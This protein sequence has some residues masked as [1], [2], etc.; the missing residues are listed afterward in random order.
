MAL[1]KTEGEVVEGLGDAF[2]VVPNA[3]WRE[4]KLFEEA[5]NKAAQ[6][7]LDAGALWPITFDDGEVLAQEYPRDR[8]LL[9][10]FAKNVRGKEMIYPWVWDLP[11]NMVSELKALG[12]WDD[13]PIN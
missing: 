3:K 2:R 10:L 5:A 9:L 6:S 8:R 1:N 7:F 12:K 11:D 4:T 13:L